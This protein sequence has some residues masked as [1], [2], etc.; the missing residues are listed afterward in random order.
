M[1]SNFVAILIFLRT[2]KKRKKVTE[3]T[4]ETYTR[5]MQ[6]Q[7]RKQLDRG[8]IRKPRTILSPVTITGNSRGVGSLGREITAACTAW[9]FRCLV[10]FYK[11]N[12]HI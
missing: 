3:S 9:T 10:W 1:S 6:L 4:A 8:I 5:E 11:I 7:L 2:N 12:A